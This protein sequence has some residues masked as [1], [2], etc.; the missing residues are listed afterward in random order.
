[1]KESIQAISIFN[2]INVNVA[3]SNKVTTKATRVI[4][5]VPLLCNKQGNFLG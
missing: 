5:T 4:I 2:N 3:V 1:M